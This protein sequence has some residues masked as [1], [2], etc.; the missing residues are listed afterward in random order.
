MD[1]TS[2]QN[3][4]GQSLR[5]LKHYVRESQ[6]AQGKESEIIQK[7]IIEELQSLKALMQRN[8]GGTMQ[9]YAATT[10]FRYFLA[11]ELD[12]MGEYDTVREI[13]AYL[14]SLDDQRY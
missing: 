4:M 10:D 8:L 6:Y 9:Q 13:L 11:R 3:Q 12:S 7:K 14:E 1:P 2:Q 5:K